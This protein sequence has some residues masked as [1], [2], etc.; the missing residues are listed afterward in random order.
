MIRMR[1]RVIENGSDR[2]SRRIKNSATILGISRRLHLNLNPAPTSIHSDGDED[3]VDENEDDVDG[4]DVDEEDKNEANN[5]SDNM[6]MPRT[7]MRLRRRVT[8]T[9]GK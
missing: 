7:Q 4:E 2:I 9:Y 8:D 6:R 1:T 5:D 3:D